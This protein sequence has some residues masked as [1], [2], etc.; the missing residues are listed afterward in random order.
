M[1]LYRHQSIVYSIIGAT[2]LA[3]AFFGWEVAHA[4]TKISA[5][6][7]ASALAGTEDVP[8]VQTATTVRTTPAAIN[9]YVKAQA[10]SASTS[11]ALA[12]GS[13]NDYN[14]GTATGAYS[15]FRV[16]P[17]ATLGSTV[18]GVVAGTANTA[19]TFLNIQTGATGVLT[20]SHQSTGSSAANRIICPGEVDL[21]VPAGD[22]VTLWRD[23]TSSRWRVK[24]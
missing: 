17:D 19:I 1:K 22:S 11:S 14:P 20:V 21:L 7:S 23:G 12:S 18:T 6:P 13:T 4:D 8:A 2:L 5:L 15:V 10:T 24:R 16:T 9:T 3:I